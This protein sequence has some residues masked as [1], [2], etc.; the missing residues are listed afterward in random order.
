MLNSIFQS[1]WISLHGL[2]TLSAL[3]I[4][5]ANSRMLHQRRH[6]SAAIA[7]CLSLALIPYVALPLYLLVG[8][9]KVAPPVPAL[10]VTALRS[11][12]EKADGPA[13]R[14]RILV[15]TL[16]LPEPSTYDLFQLHE[17]GSEALASLLSIIDTAT[18]RL[19]ICTFL[20][21]RDPL[22][23][24]IARRLMLSARRGVSVRLM[25]DGIG[26]FLGGSPDL[27]PL[28]EAGVQVALFA[29][30]LRFPFSGRA[31]LRNHRK[32]A[33]ADGD[34][35]WMG[36]RNLAAEY[37]EGSRSPRR[38]RACWVDLSFELS[39][40]V[41]GQAQRR[42]DCD[43]AFAARE[44]LDVSL[45]YP[46]APAPA[47]ALAV[48][49]ALALA[50]SHVATVQLVPSGPDQREDTVY[51]LLI[52]SCFAAETRILAVSPYYV[53][54]AALQMALALAARRGIDVDLLLPRR[55][56][57]NMADMA[58]NASLR[59]L[60]AAGVRI[61]L[62]PGMI[63][64]KAVVID[65]QLALAGSANLDERSLFLNYEMMVAFYQR[66]DVLRFAAWIERQCT[67][68][69]RFVTRQPGVVREFGEG[70]VRWLAFQL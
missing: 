23:R 55:S 28:A 53:P 30:P 52:S 21:G 19:D 16:D 17:D 13:A 22:G 54:D 56:N 14:L 25:V 47:P 40:A 3:G 32:M 4:Y 68:A 20:I 51:T 61:W 43:W 44:P 34:R 31:N 60:A 48:A 11:E 64:A 41:A 29:S 24:E 58:R 35:L 27:R 65:D 38:K 2:V 50:P 1:H 37:F 7:W 62:S 10:T 12:H 39:G 57:H 45:Q 5:L 6:P 69:V 36:G 18:T 49:L 67:G 46:L 8:R 59:E 9:R 15:G 42:F 66:D 33:I 63:H 26:R 70:M